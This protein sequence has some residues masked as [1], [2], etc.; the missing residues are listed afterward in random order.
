MSEVPLQ[1]SGRKAVDLEVKRSGK[2]C[3]EAELDLED[4]NLRIAS[5]QGYLAHK[6]RRFPRTLQ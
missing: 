5:M 3:T 1:G 2:Q 6:K 4:V